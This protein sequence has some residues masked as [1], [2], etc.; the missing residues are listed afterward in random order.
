MYFYLEFQTQFVD[1]FLMYN[2]DIYIIIITI[3]III[4]INNN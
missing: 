3:T 1:S 2:Q 4:M